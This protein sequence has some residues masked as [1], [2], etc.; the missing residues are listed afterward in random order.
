M[1]NCILITLVGFIVTVL[2]A[3]WLG[4]RHADRLVEAMAKGQEKLLAVIE[5]RWRE[6]DKRLGRIEL[7]YLP[8]IDGH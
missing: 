6:I 1:T 3:N 4:M 2:T 8:E 7:R 5:E